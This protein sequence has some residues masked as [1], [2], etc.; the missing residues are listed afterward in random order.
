M[1]LPILNRIAELLKR[2]NEIAIEKKGKKGRGITKELME[3]HI[4][5]FPS[6]IRNMMNHYISTYHSDNLTILIDTH[7]QTDVSGITN[8]SPVNAALL[9]STIATEMRMIPTFSR[10]ESSSTTLTEPSPGT[11]RIGGHPKGTTKASK[12]A[13]N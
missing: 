10:T 3:E 5:K 6:L 1:Q 7:H 2:R 12:E 4:K 13:L 9:C 8:T 11:S